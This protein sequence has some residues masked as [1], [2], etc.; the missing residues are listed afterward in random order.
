MRLVFIFLLYIDFSK[1]VRDIF[2]KRFDLGLVKLDV[3]INLC[4]KVEI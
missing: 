1:V 2:N 4:R 3:K